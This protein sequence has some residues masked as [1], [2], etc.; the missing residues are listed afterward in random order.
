MTKPFWNAARAAQRRVPH[1]LSQF[2]PV[3]WDGGGSLGDGYEMDCCELCGY[4]VHAPHCPAIPTA[5]E[6][7]PMG[8]LRACPTCG[9]DPESVGLSGAAID[10]GGSPVGM[11]RAHYE[12]REAW[13]AKQREPSYPGWRP[14]GPADPTAWIHD[15]EAWAAKVEP[16]KF[17]WAM[18][19]KDVVT[20]DHW[21][22]TIEEAMAAALG[23]DIGT[24]SDGFFYSS[25]SI[26]GFGFST[27]QAAAI[28]ALRAQK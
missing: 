6:Q 26:G 15:T 25:D 16:D 18:A 28:A 1:K 2:D 4:I 9:W 27:T 20:R 8:N 13:L 12:H 11:N 7:K 22:D 3:G 17:W 5:P 21:K 19:G 23:I 10:C 24:D 14:D